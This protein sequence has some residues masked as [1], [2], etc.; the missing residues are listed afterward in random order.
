VKVQRESWRRRGGGGV[1]KEEEAPGECGG[2]LSEEYPT[3][4]GV[5]SGSTTVSKRL[6]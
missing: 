2:E 6:F 4:L 3:L 1:K 5:W